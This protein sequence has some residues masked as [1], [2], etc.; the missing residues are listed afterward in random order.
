MRKFQDRGVWIRI[1]IRSFKK[2][3]I[4]IRLVL[5]GSIRIRAISERIR[6][7]SLHTQHYISQTSFMQNFGRSNMR[8]IYICSN[9]ECF[10]QATHFQSH[11]RPNF[12]R[13]CDHSLVVYA[14]VFSRICGCFDCAICIYDFFICTYMRNAAVFQYVYTPRI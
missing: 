3:W 8:R 7:P 11:M 4:R 2:S 6:N 12:S 13:I 5:R 1:T 10:A 14:T 9:C